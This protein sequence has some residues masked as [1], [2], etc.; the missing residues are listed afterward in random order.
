MSVSDVSPRLRRQSS[1]V[2]KS[3]IDCRLLVRKS[4]IDGGR[5][6]FDNQLSNIQLFDNQVSI[7][8]LFDNQAIHSASMIGM[9]I[10]MV[11]AVNIHCITPL[12]FCC[13]VYISYKPCRTKQTNQPGKMRQLLA[14]LPIAPYTAPKRSL[15]V[16]H[17]GGERGLDTTTNINNCTSSRQASSLT[18]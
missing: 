5:Q 16:S 14:S 15:F 17:G 10:G 1:I 8:R 18:G 3:S 9:Q 7:V 6:L 4:S 12:F 11:R 2:R 13:A